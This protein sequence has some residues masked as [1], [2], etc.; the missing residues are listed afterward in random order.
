MTGNATRAPGSQLVE[1]YGSNTQSVTFTPTT[2]SVVV[3]GT[4]DVNSTS[5]STSVE[6]YLLTNSYNTVAEG[7]ETSVGAFSSTVSGL[8]AG[9]QYVLEVIPTN[10]YYEVYVYPPN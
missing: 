2:G 4:V 5:Q 6:W 9:V 7:K 3:Q 10:V 8:T 1:I